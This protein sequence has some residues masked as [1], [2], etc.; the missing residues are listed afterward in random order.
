MAS[1]RGPLE[2]ISNDTGYGDV[3]PAWKSQLRAHFLLLDV[4]A[5]TE[6]DP[7]T[8]M[9]SGGP[10][11]SANVEITNSTHNSEDVL[12]DSTLL[13]AMAGLDD[14]GARLLEGLEAGATVQRELRQLD[15][16]T[17]SA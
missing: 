15:R 3:T 16:K 5:S 17:R 13:Q 4:D 11:E 12:A 9:H 6:T 8:F 10:L 7:P 14:A 2:D 1:S